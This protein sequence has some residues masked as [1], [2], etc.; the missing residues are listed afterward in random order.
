MAATPAA[1]E[2]VRSHAVRWAALGVGL[3]MVLLVVLL[4]TSRRADEG[5]AA[6]PVLG[7]QAPALGGEALI[8]E[9]FDIGT[10]DRWL[11]VNFFATWCVPCVQEHPELRKFAADTAED[12]RGQVVSVAYDDEPSEVEAFFE[13]RGGEWTVLDADDGRT[14]LDWGVAKVPESFLVAPNGIVVERIQGGV[15]AADVEAIIAAYEGEE[16]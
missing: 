14:A 2:P 8:G 16:P 10:N 4:V 9:P 12:G 3:V 6:S 11:L 15:R 5:E 1:D 13:E 7:E